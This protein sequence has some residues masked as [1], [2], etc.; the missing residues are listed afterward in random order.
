MAPVLALVRRVPLVVLTLVVGAAALALVAVGLEPAARWGVSLYALAIAAVEAVRMIRGLLARRLGLDVL[1]VTAI[2]STVAVGEYAASLIIVLMLTGGE[3]LEVAAAGRAQRELRA[4]LER[5][6]QQAHRIDSTGGIVDIAAD[7]VRVGDRLLVRPA[8]LVPVDSALV[9]AAASIDESSLTGESMPVDKQAG[10]AVLSG[11]LNG[12]AAVEVVAMAVAA[13]SQYQRIVELVREA[14]ASTAPLV[15]LADRYAV[16]FTA[17]SLAI[18]GVA[19]MLSGD[20]VRFAEVLVVATPCPLLIAA[21]VAFMGGMSSAAKRGIVMKSAASLEVLARARTVAFDKTGTLTAG[22][23]AVVGVHP[24]PGVSADELLRLVG[25]AERYSSHVLAAALRDAAAGAGLLL[26]DSDDAREE[27]TFGVA[28]T[29]DGRSVVVG[30]PAFVE[31]RATGV[32]RSAI[33]RGRAVVYAGV[34]GVFAGT[35]ELRDG[36]RPEAA[37]TLAAL[38]RAGLE[39]TIML[40]GDVEATARPIAEGL[41]IAEVHAEC[42]PEDKVALVRWAQP[43]PVIM[44]GDGVNDA[45]VLAV[46]DVGV[47]MGATGSTAASESADVVIMVDDLTRVAWAVVIGQRTV[48]IALQS[49]GLGIAVSIA[50]MLVAAA[51]LLPAVAGALLQELVDLLAI[52]GA[53]RAVRAGRAPMPGLDGVEARGAGARPMRASEVLRP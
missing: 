45:P 28:A 31:Q 16:P 11:S 30:K 35:I 51:G 49:I 43:R 17:V 1:A 29:I 15:R 9:S 41:G 10:D 52:L 44:V 38:R 4:L 34:D 40:T 50:L 33:E 12:A 53:L 8:E 20:P 47:A 27:A 46:A 25:S 48:R 18:A 32:R 2:V 24:E 36:V 13:D 39:R 14:T 21:P 23:P 7:Q 6:P 37:R 19:W 42:L 26:A 3:A 5:V 22:H